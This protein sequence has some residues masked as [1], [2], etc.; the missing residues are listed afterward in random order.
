MAQRGEAGRAMGASLASSGV[1]ALVGAVVLGASIPI[2]RPLVLTF[3]SPE[4]FALTVLGVTFIA[5]LSSDSLSKGVLMGG[6][7][8]LLATVG[9]SPHT[10]FLR[11]TFSQTYLF[12]G[13][14]LIPVALGLFAIPEII[15]LAVRGTSIADRKV[16]KIGGVLQGVRDTGTHIWLVLRCGGISAFV[17][18]IPGLGSAAAQWVSYA[19]AVQS[20]PR[21]EEFGTGRVEGVLAPGAS[22]NAKEGGALIPTVAFGVPGS[23]AMA[24]LLGAFLMVGLIPGPN[25]LTTNLNVTFSLVWILVVANFISIGI[26]F[27]FLNQLAKITMIK[28]TLLI[29]VLLSL[30]WLGSFSASS[31]F[32]DLIAL[33]V[34]GAVGVAMV[35]LDWPRPPL[36]LGL[37]LGGLTDV[38]LFR[39]V[40]RYGAPFLYRPVVAVVLVL[41]VASLVYAVVQGRRLRA[42]RAA[43]PPPKRSQSIGELLFAGLLAAIFAFAVFTGA[44]WRFRDQL[45]PLAIAAPMLV[46]VSATLVRTLHGILAPQAAVVSAAAAGAVAGGTTA[47]APQSIAERAQPGMEA[48]PEPDTEGRRRR[49]F[50]MIGWVGVSFVLM[51]LVGFREGLPTFVF[52]FLRFQS[53]ERLWL[54]VLI[55]AATGILLHQFF[56][57]VL[58][59]PWPEPQLGTWLGFD[60]P[61]M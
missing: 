57:S 30:V 19:H 7:G 23:F 53:K 40:D 45:F 54:S 33:V 28:G 34:F 29:P 26:A 38:Y 42:R 15:D 10:G 56:G 52:L 36:V 39:S 14:S 58:H 27:L 20:S 6:F 21:P 55:A 49:F 1:G 35:K 11:Y 51:W 24:I 41:A 60:W 22:A 37:V 47:E 59:Y 17:G 46:L 18:L 43:V 25:M 4:L 31:N 12:D 8:F 5:S 32:G 48:V 50:Q 44:G 13:I 9:Q 61:G 16:G 2:V 3:A